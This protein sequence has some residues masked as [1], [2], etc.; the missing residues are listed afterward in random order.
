MDEILI[1]A[2]LADTIA[3]FSSFSVPDASIV[4]ALS[5]PWT[6]RCNIRYRA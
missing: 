5:L 6:P 2:R 1:A 3:V 4:S